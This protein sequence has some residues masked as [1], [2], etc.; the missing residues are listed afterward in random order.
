MLGP[1]LQRTEVT[2]D[3]LWAWWKTQ[4]VSGP[5]R[6]CLVSLFVPV[7]AVALL[8]V[9]ALLASCFVAGSSDSVKHDKWLKAT[10]IHLCHLKGFSVRSG[11]SYKCEFAQVN[12]Y[13]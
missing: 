1:E 6:I 4:A 12:C 8:L 9:V 13:R 2:E 5:M 7:A 3:P 11:H 10:M